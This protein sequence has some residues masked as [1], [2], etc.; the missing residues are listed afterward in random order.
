MRIV[1]R[2]GGSVIA[3]PANPKLI[4]RYAKLLKRL[5]E[6]GH[7]VIA[8]VGGGALA[9]EFIMMGKEIGL[10]QQ[11]QDWLA[12]HVSRLYA[13]L[14]ILKLGK[15]GVEISTSISNAARAL[16]EGGVVVM[17]GLEPG[18]TTDAVAA[19]TALEIKAKLLVKATDQDGVYD[20]DPAK[21]KEAKR[22]D[23]VTFSG[24]AELF[25]QRSHEAGL[26]QILDPVA[27][28]ILRNRSIKTI[29]VNG[30]NPENVLH[31]IEGRNV[32]TTI[33]Q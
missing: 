15:D 5:E 11:Q 14:F 21:Y 3:S 4:D 20:K 18:M 16:R 29:I 9:R 23:N 30:F 32:G 22:L 31:A 27:V 25:E 24:L 19:R 26:H 10:S 33:T 7:E 17:G 6:L 8:V 2:I 28:E 1:L 13:L 12:I